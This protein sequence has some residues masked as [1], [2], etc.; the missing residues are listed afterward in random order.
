M[1]MMMMMIVS[2]FGQLNDDDGDDN[3]PVWQTWA[4]GALFGGARR[5]AS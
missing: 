3:K 2:P 5:M 1:M 4:M